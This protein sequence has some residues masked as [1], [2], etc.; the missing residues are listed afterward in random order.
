MVMFMVYFTDSLLP[1]K[2][3]LTQLLQ[4]KNRVVAAFDGR[5]AAGKSSAAEWLAVQLGGEV[6]HMDDFFLPLELRTLERLAEPGGNVHR[7]RFETEVLQGLVSG[8]VFRYRRFD[9]SV[10]DYGESVSAGDKRLIIIEGAY[11]LHP[12]FGNYYDLAV[13]FDIDP[14]EQKSRIL[15]R[16]GPGK[17]VAFTQRWIP[18]EER[19][20]SAFD[21]ENRCDMVIKGGLV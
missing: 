9:C 5:S 7:E 16:D 15:R 2:N 6:I 4:S 14:E 12:S 11:S 20:I 21:I 1:L 10:M 3:R 18:M 17:L 19:Y 8:E 13:F